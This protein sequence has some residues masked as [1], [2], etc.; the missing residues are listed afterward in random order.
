MFQRA[1]V[2]RPCRNLAKGL[3]AAGLG[4]PDHGLAVRQH[5]AYI[6]ALI[7]C[8]LQVT[9]LEADEEYPDSVF[10]EDTAVL[11][12]ECAVITRPG[13]PSR[14]GETAAVRAAV[15]R[16][17]D[18]VAEIAPDGTLDGGDVMAAGR[19]L[20]IGLSRRT[21]AAGA[22]ALAALLQPHGYIAATVP[23]RHVL[24]LKTGVVPLDDD[25]LVVAGEFADRP[26]FRGFTRIVVDPG[27]EYAA[28]CLWINDRVLVA[29]GYPRLRARIEAAGFATIVLDMSEFRKLDGGLS[30]LSLR[31]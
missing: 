6:E 23:L 14:R 27:E 30:C 4:V 13:A 29:D 11:T 24:H 22:G 17:F 3:T 20:F 5:D 9:V 7:A 18:P 12:P 10:I 19:R 1:I 28:N 21:S 26:E 8:G 31:F 2:K 16:F 15:S 25:T